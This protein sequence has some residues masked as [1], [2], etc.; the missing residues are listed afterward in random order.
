MFVVCVDI[1]VHPAQAAAFV[2]AT[3]VNAHHTRLEPGNVRFD[4]LRQ[5]AD[6]ARFT[7]VEAY[8]SAEDFAAHQRTP[9][10]LAW[11]ETVAP[12]M[13]FPRVGTRHG[14]LFPADAD[15]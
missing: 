11:K 13:A 4:V 12:W 10:Y 5:E 9:H 7:L 2:A 14:S 8:R 6:A 3:L 15:W 1:R